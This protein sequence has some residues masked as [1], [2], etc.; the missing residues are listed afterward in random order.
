MELS[1]PR[2]SRLIVESAKVAESE[3]V[4]YGFVRDSLMTGAGS[5]GT[6]ALSG[7]ATIVIARELGPSRRGDWAAIFSLA[8]LV[9]TIAGLGL[10]AAG[11]YGA[12][13]LR[14]EARQRFVIGVVWVSCGLGLSCAAVYLVVAEV[15]RPGHG[16]TSAIAGGS[17]IAAVTLVQNVVAQLALATARLRWFVIAQLVPAA[18]TL[19]A[20]ALLAGL[21]RLTLVAVVVVYAARATGASFLA[22]A[23]LVEARVIAPRARASPRILRP[24]LSYALMTFATLSLTQIVQR[25]D[26]LLVAGLRGSRQAGLYAVAVQL[27]ELLIVVPG[28]LGFVLFRRSARSSHRHWED[29]MRALRWTV[30]IQTVAAAVLFA[31]APEVVSIVFGAGYRDSV[32]AVRWLM[33]GA[34]MLGA[35]TVASNYIAGRGRPRS[36]LVAWGAGAIVGVGLNILVIPVDGIAGAAA[37]SSLALGVVFALHL[38]ALRTVHLTDM[39]ATNARSDDNG[40]RH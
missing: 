14:G 33:P 26:V 6:I 21:H 25:V 27:L 22:V 8:T 40:D 29:A 39:S 17:V 24:Y 23:G 13:Q 28:A 11:G 38:V 1:R 4:S 12:A 35:Q 16:P 37:V 32:A 20:I 10:P 5:V 30:S 9:A 34:V 31:A 15:A 19:T 36:V 2:D 3:R 18:G 7:L